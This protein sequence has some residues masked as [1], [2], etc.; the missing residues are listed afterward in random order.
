LP[1]TNSLVPQTR[2]PPRGITGGRA[3]R[4]RHCVHSALN[5]TALDHSLTEKTQQY[6]ADARYARYKPSRASGPKYLTLADDC[7]RSVAWCMAQ[8][9]RARGRR[10]ERWCTVVVPVLPS[11]SSSSP[12]ST[13]TS[14]S[15]TSPR[16]LPRLIRPGPRSYGAIEFSS[17]RR[18]T[19]NIHTVGRVPRT[20]RARPPPLPSPTLS[21]IPATCVIAHT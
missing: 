20:F 5:V 16:A 6:R 1:S 18:R 17:P 12:S 4:G 21:P 7:Y 8:R 11:S 14:P 9:K 2:P 10:C 19:L 15:S 3:A 13:S